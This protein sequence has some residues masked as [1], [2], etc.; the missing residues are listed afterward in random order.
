[1]RSNKRKKRYNEAIMG[2][3]LEQLNGSHF[4]TCVWK[5]RLI[6]IIAQHRPLFVDHPPKLL[7][8]NQT[9]TWLH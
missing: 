3:G 4:L 8:N 1:M 2:R 6:E 5:Y 7:V 9:D